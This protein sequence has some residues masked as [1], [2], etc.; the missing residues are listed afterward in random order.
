[1]SDPVL[2][3]AGIQM[4]AN[5]C[6]DESPRSWDL[7]RTALDKGFQSID[8]RLKHLG[9]LQ[10]DRFSLNEANTRLTALTQNW[11]WRA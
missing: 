5:A 11:R 1:M 9:P 6:P 7:L 4:L 10:P 8:E 2:L 3:E